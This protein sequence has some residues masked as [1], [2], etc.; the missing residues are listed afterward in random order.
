M[1]NNQKELSNNDLVMITGGFC[2]ICVC[3]NNSKDALSLQLLDQEIIISNVG[4]IV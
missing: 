4:Q 3:C 1:K 2:N